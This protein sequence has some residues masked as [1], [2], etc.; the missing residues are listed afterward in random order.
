MIKVFQNR[1][2]I[3]I[4][5]F[6]ISSICSAKSPSQYEEAKK[7]T[8][9]F[10]EAETYKAVENKLV[11]TLINEH[12]SQYITKAIKNQASNT[13]IKLSKAISN[14]NS[15]ER[16]K[17][18]KNIAGVSQKGLKTLS[19]LS[20]S[21]LRQYVGSLKNTSSFMTLRRV[22]GKTGDKTGNWILKRFSE[23]DGI[24]SQGGKVSDKLLQKILNT[25]KKLPP[26]RAKACYEL[27][28][29]KMGTDWKQITKGG[30]T[31]AGF[32]GSMVDGVFVLKDAY[33]IYYI[34]DSEEKAIQASSKIIDYGTGTAGG[35]AVGAAET[36]VSTT[37]AG[38][39]AT[40][41][42]P[43][44]VVALSANRVA[45][46]Y[47]EIM[48][49]QRDREKTKSAELEEKLQNGITVRRAMLQTS[50]YIQAGEIKK[51]KKMYSKI[52]HFLLSGVQKRF[53]NQKKVYHLFDIL[54][55]KL[56]KAQRV[57]E[58]NKI[59]NQARFPY[60]KAVNLYNTNSRLLYAKKLAQQSLEIL[61]INSGQYPEIHS[62]K[63]W[64]YIKNL[65]NKINQ[66]I[67]NAKPLKIVS[68]SGPKVVVAGESVSYFLSIKGGVP[69]YKPVNIDGYGTNKSVT[70]YWVAP[71]EIGKKTLHFTIQDAL[72]K[73]ATVNI[74]VTIINRT[75]TTTTKDIKLVAFTK[76][77]HQGDKLIIENKVHEVYPGSNDVNFLVNTNNPNYSYI[78]KVNGVKESGRFKNKFYLRVASEP[79]PKIGI[80]G[81]GVNTITVEVQDK[82]GN[83]IGKDS[84]V[85]RVKDFQ[86][87]DYWDERNCLLPGD[88][89]GMPEDITP[90]ECI[91]LTREHNSHIKR[92]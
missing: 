65:I 9:V 39:V 89:E 79:Q 26:E 61:S 69:D 53:V 49:L 77:H 64:I 50:Q 19:T 90:E 74:S 92:R 67:A 42:L 76:F 62:L 47:T 25:A 3:F 38:S 83:S 68:V 52:E 59:I 27:M 81:I 13:M 55:E 46:L 2:I 36:A 29:K 28:A 45:T 48:E 63:A 4:F 44:L 8:A 60:Y 30:S 10:I 84:W 88:I 73:K 43:G 1:S 87:T 82:N 22:I 51:A 32:V 57:E 6:F 34:D 71:Q 80:I 23:V 91:K 56:K 14:M 18:L 58:I 20:Q 35:V 72:G 33:T 7:T 24:A 85:I 12:H 70:L 37:V 5:L 31:T 17:I 66:K 86:K 15:N 21:S 54:K 16:I 11:E 40:A 75:N 41:I 78:W